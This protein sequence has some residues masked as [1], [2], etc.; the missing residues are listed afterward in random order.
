[1]L[2]FL[3]TGCLAAPADPV[4]AG[5]S[6]DGGAGSGDAVTTRCVAGSVLDLA[7]ISKLSVGNAANDA[8]ILSGLAVFANPG[9]DTIL[10]PQVT[11]TAV[12]GDPSILATASIAGGEAGMVL[13]PGEAKGALVSTAAPLVQAT[14][15][16]AWNDTANPTLEESYLLS[17]RTAD[18]PWADIDVPIQVQAGD[19]MFAIVVTLTGDEEHVTGTPL[20]AA[21]TRATCE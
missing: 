15:A 9:D 14:F 16:E 17:D 3:V 18:Q 8:V 7:Y 12:G 10:V 4:G 6:A 2:L 20:A 1:M 19:Y 21:R 13:A 5:G 11:A